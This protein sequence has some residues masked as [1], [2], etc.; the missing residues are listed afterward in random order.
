MLGWQHAFNDINPNSTMAFATGSN[1]LISG[2]PIAQDSALF[3]AGLEFKNPRHDALKMNLYYQG[4][5]AGK[6]ANNGVSAAV[7]WSF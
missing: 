1:F 6:Y 2:T 7:N 4:A 5:W 3:N